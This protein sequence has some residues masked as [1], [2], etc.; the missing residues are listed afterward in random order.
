MFQDGYQESTT[1]FW[2]TSVSVTML[3]WAD[4]AMPPLYRAEIGHTTYPSEY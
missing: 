2:E 4:K 1:A 3:K